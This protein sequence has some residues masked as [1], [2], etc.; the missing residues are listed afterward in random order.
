MG[1]LW[2]TLGRF[3]LQL[4]LER[5]IMLKR[6][7]SLLILPGLHA[8]AAPLAVRGAVR[9]FG[10][11]IAA[12]INVSLEVIHSGEKIHWYLISRSSCLVIETCN[13]HRGASL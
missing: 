4:V 11:L 12:T 1:F 2:G 7:R 3:G 8:P 9:A 5:G 13:T 10:E 6:R